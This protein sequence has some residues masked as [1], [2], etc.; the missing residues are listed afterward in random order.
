MEDWIKINLFGSTRCNICNNTTDFRSIEEGL[1][2]QLR[3]KGFPYSLDDFETLNYKH[4][5]CQL[6][7][8]SD[9]DRLYKLYFD[10]YPL[11]KHTRLLD[12]APST[13]LQSCLKK[14]KNVEY[15]SADLYMKEVDDV[16]DITD[17]DLYSDESFDFFVCSHLLEHVDDTKAL[18]ELY[19][20]LK[21][22]GKGILMTPIIDDD[23]VFDEDLSLNDISER[24]RRFAQDDHVR[25]YSKRVFLDRVSN[26]GFHINQL[27]SRNFSSRLFRTYGISEKSVL[28]IVEK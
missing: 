17:M 10:K 4:Y 8:S 27:T 15:R 21:K 19:R 22:G 5:L 3:D 24:W 14:I 28:Y 20:V 1:G 7:Q 23:G 13:A 2:A 16:V 9:R 25:L 12:F 26:S 6:C 18:S 11:K